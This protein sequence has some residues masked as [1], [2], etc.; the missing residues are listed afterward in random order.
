MSSTIKC[1]EMSDTFYSL[2]T[3]VRSITVESADLLFYVPLETFQLP[4]Y[5]QLSASGLTGICISMYD[6]DLHRW[7]IQHSPVQPIK[8]GD[9]PGSVVKVKVNLVVLNDPLKQ[10]DVHMVRSTLDSECGGPTADLSMSNL[11]LLEQR[12]QSLEHFDYTFNAKHRATAREFSPVDGCV[13]LVASAPKGPAG[14]HLCGGGF[15]SVYPVCASQPE[16]IEDSHSSGKGTFNAW[17]VTATPHKGLAVISIWIRLRDPR[18]WNSLPSPDPLT[19]ILSLSPSVETTAASISSIIDGG[20]PPD[21]LLS[22]WLSENSLEAEVES[23]EHAFR[24]SIPFPEHQSFY[25]SHI[26]SLNLRDSLDF[27]YS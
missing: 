21:Q 9:K 26:A 11:A 5:A 14:F 6:P 10:Y 15:W 7:V 22:S 3:C 8:G 24:I 12:R 16:W 25:L 13:T 2:S 4:L 23:D 17:S 19:S 27:F 1:Q 18:E 20:V